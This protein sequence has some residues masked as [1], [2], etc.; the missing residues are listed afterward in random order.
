MG[1]GAGQC[2][3]PAGIATNSSTGN[4]YVVD[5]GNNRINEFTVWGVFVKAWGWGVRDGESELQTCTTETGC[6]D[7]LEG[8]GAGQVGTKTTEVRSVAVD[9]HGDVYIYESLRCTGGCV[10]PS[11]NRVQKFDAEGNFLLM[12]GG[13]VDEGPN[14]AFRR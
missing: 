4:I 10:T 1:E 11:N 6:R 13:G 3:N 5:S 9:S 7:G 14:H 2:R 12:F 8:S